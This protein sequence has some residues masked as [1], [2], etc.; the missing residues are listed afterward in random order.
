MHIDLEAAIL[1]GN[2]KLIKLKNENQ[3]SRTSNLC[4]RYMTMVDILK[5]FN[6]PE[7]TGDWDLHLVTL[8]EMLP[9]CAAAG[10]KKSL[11]KSVYLYIQQMLSLPVDHL[12][13]YSMFVEG[14]HG[15]RRSD[16]YWA[17]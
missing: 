9:Y 13:V 8:H 7:R 16:R 1:H 4:F 14:R 6:Q 17:A 10:H 2:A 12:N 3:R 11:Y 5:L 15:I